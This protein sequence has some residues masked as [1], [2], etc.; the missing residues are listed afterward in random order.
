MRYE[1]QAASMTQAEVARLL[2]R[3][4]ALRRSH[5]DL[6]N[7]R[8][9]LQK[10]VDDLSRENGELTRQVEWFRRQLLGS[11]SERRVADPGRQLF[12]AETDAA[13][14]TED[15]PSDGIE[16]AAYRRRRR[17]RPAE[18]D[19]GFRFDPPVPIVTVVVPNDEVPAEE[20]DDYYVVS[21]KVT[22]RLGQRPAS[23]VV[24][25][26]IREVLK[27]KSDGVFSCPPAPPR[28]SRGAWWT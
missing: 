7:T 5:H 27:R 16:V 3:H 23:Y 20:R 14:V 10:T 11:K 12:L 1:E 15:S 8:H 17:A 21:Q 24:I 19:G 6:Q 22:D 26:E 25:R 28:S 9:D 13:Q 2:A 4:D 18:E